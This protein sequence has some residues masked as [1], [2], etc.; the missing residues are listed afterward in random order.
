[1]DRSVDGPKSTV[2]PRRSG[3][4]GVPTPAPRVPRL[5]QTAPRRWYRRTDRSVGPPVSLQWASQPLSLPLARRGARARAAASSRPHTYAY[6]EIRVVGAQTHVR[7]VACTRR[8]AVCELHAHGPSPSFSLH[9][10]PPNIPPRRATILRGEV[11]I[12]RT[13]REGVRVPGSSLA[14]AVRSQTSTR[15]A[16]GV[17][18]YARTHARNTTFKDHED[19]SSPFSRPF[20]NAFAPRTRHVRRTTTTTSLPNDSSTRERE[21]ETRS[22]SFPSP[23]PFF[24]QE[25]RIYLGHRTA[26]RISYFSHLRADLAPSTASLVERREGEEPTAFWQFSRACL[27]RCVTLPCVKLLPPPLVVLR[28][29]G[30]RR[31]ARI[32]RATVTGL[33]TATR[34]SCSLSL[35]TSRRDTSAR[36]KR[37]TAARK[38]ELWREL[39]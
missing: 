6:T 12:R 28:F 32:V 15:Q 27:H 9:P 39:C 10:T 23:S 11:S 7:S 2:R 1:M 19:P 34:K 5:R 22:T 25:R 26:A 33:A 8:A 21:R 36:G 37:R 13:T 3:A 31:S 4:G 18:T 17:R 38:G 20:D 16:R 14:A 29:E 35:S 30:I 24:L